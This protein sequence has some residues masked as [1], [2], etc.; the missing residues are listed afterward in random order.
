MSLPHDS[1]TPLS[2]SNQAKKIQVAEMF[3][4]I[5]KRYDFMNRFLSARVDRYWR[6]KALRPLKPFHLVPTIIRLIK[7][8]RNKWLPVWLP[9]WHVQFWNLFITHFAS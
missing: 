2:N 7:Y 6:K 4:R 5:A 1:I 8:A 9:V 3:N